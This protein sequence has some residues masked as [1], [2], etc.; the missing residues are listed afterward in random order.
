[1]PCTQRNMTN[2]VYEDIM[3]NNILIAT[4]IATTILVSG[5]GAAP[6]KQS[7]PSAT[8]NSSG[9]PLILDEVD[10]V[11]TRMEPKLDRCLAGGRCLT[12][13]ELEA[14]STLAQAAT[15]CIGA[16]YL[17]RDVQATRARSKRV[18][19]KLRTIGKRFG[20]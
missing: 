9:C 10:R 11:H 17:P 3:T 7:P 13:N 1:M 2:E 16:G 4:T 20:G 15:A 14:S 12:V 8:G 19:R 6:I 5:C 18:A